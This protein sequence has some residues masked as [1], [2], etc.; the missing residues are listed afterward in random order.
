MAE[1]FSTDRPDAQPAPPNSPCLCDPFHTSYGFALGQ[2]IRDFV[3]VP[4]R[5][6]FEKHI[7][8]SLWRDLVCTCL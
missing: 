1:F 8:Q 2:L 7:G 4:C 3:R 5:A 6:F